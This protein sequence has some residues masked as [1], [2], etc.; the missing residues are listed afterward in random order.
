M[1]ERFLNT[2]VIIGLLF[3]PAVGVAEWVTIGAGNATCEHWNRANANQETEILSWMAGFV[4]A[5]NLGRAS[6]GQQ[7]FRLELLTYDY[8]RHQI[9]DTCSSSMNRNKRMLHILMK[10]LIEFPINTK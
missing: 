8:L 2:L 1:A 6:K 10:T 9:D 5:E 3:T 7:E 4:S